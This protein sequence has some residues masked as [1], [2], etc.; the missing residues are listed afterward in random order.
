[1]QSMGRI[2]TNRMSSAVFL[3][4]FAFFAC[5]AQRQAVAA[6]VRASSSS[7]CAFALDGAIED[8]DSLALEKLLKESRLHDLD[9]RSTTICLSSP[10]GSFE[11]SMKLTDLIYRSGLSTIIVS[12]AECYSACAFVFMSGVISDRAAPYRKLS[13][14][15]TLGFHAPYLSSE[16]GKYTKDQLEELSEDVRKAVLSLLRLSVKKTQLRGSEFLKKSLL[17]RI[18]ESGPNEISVVR[19]VADAARWDV[20]IY[21]ADE[22]FPEPSPV[23]AMKNVCNNFHYS[24]I[25][26]SV[27]LPPELF[28]KVENYS[29]KF[30]KEDFRVLVVDSQ[31]D[32]TVCEIYPR[33]GVQSTISYFGCAYDYWS[34][35]SFGDCREYKTSPLFGEHIPSFFRF[36]P[37]R[38]LKGAH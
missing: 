32:N 12:G 29:S 17:I 23:E 4:S 35:S 1:M 7:L 9:E 2:R 19:T 26:E 28:V 5:A 30:H 20:E 18:L 21:D 8:G 24:K 31:S 33:T 36:A 22:L 10:G 13:A 14:R 34:S 3:L 16:G 15:A 27:T 38:L 25:D 37:D 11:E 6:E